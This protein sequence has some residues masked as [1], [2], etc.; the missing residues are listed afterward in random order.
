MVA[1]L[2]PVA[3]MTPALLSC[4]PILDTLAVVPP[5]LPPVP[6]TVNVPPVVARP[7]VAN[8]TPMLLGLAPVPPPVPVMVRSPASVETAAFE[9]AT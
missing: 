9:F 3:R 7:V 6:S 2:V 4:T 8:S 1:A 5:A